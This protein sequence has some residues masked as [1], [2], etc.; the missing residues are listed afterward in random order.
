[1]ILFPFI[2]KFPS[3]GLFEKY[4][5]GF[6]RVKTPVSTFCANSYNWNSS[7]PCVTYGVNVY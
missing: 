3:G 2:S 4:S 6:G 1:M 5:V 7:S